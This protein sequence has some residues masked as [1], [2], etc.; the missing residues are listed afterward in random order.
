MTSEFR[1][2]TLGPDMESGTL[3]AWQVKP[4][5]TVKHGDIVAQVETDKGVIDVEIFAAGTVQKLLVEPGAHVP[6]G[7]VLAQLSGE[8]PTDVTSAVPERINEIEPAR[9]APEAALPTLP[10]AVQKRQKIS[11]AARARAHALG[12]DISRVTGTGAGAVVTLEDINRLAVRSAPATARP[13]ADQVHDMRRVIGKAMSRSKRE[14]PHYYLSM[15]CC[16]SKARSWL[17]QHNSS[18]SIEQRLLPSALLLKAVALAAHA[19]PDFNG[20]YKDEAFVPSSDVHVGMAIAMRGGRLVAPAIL[21]G[22]QKSLPAIMSEL[23]DLATRVRAGHM[24]ATELALSTITV[25]SLAEEGVGSLMPIIYPPQV[26]IVGF[27]SILEQPWV[28]GGAVCVA[29]VIAISLAADHRVT[30]GRAGARFLRHIHD[31]LQA[32]EAL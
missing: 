26:A 25:T 13:S 10:P 1:M 18:A 15:D 6:V 5:D 23:R 8:E 30:D 28:V 16:F 22:D 20:Y 2:P 14:I 31:A 12:I 21:N 32:P 9:V 3:V 4:G 27:G 17:E 24:R 11:P 7:T 29:P 19:L